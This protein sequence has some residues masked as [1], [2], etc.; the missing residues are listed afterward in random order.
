MKLVCKDNRKGFLVK[1]TQ[2]LTIGKEYTIFYQSETLHI[3]SGF[4]VFD[5]S[6][7]WNKYPLYFFEPKEDQ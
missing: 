6:G 5:D 1:T 2:P 7:K 4:I 3:H